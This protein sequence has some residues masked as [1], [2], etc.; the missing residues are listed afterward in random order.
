MTDVVG[1]TR[2]ILLIG[3]WVA[4]L[5]M[6][7]GCGYDPPPESDLQLPPTGTYELGEPLAIVFTEPIVVDSLAIRVWP[8]GPE[9]RTIENEL[10]PG[11][12]PAV[13]VCRV[14][15]G[16][17]GP[18]KLEVADDRL[19]A[20]LTLVG[21]PFDKAKVPWQ[22]EVLAGLRDDAGRESGAPDLFDFQFVPP[23]VC[24]ADHPIEFDDGVYVLLGIIEDPL[25]ATLIMFSDMKVLENGELRW[26]GGKATAIDGAP[27]N[28]SN[29]DE[30]AIDTTDKGFAIFPV[31]CVTDD[32]TE[33]F[34]TTEP[35]DLNLAF[36]PLLVTLS[37]LRLTGTIGKHPETGEDRIEGTISFSGILLD[38][39]GG[40]PFEYPPG[41]TGFFM[42]KVPLD[43]IPSEA[44]R[45]CG[46]L[47]GDITAQCNPPEG[48]PG[49]EFC[50]AEGASE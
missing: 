16:A 39:G 26:V 22:L 32:G 20:T 8:A 44:P 46:A 12:P 48:Y 19:S 24:G 21:A 29:P 33:R 47:C 9:D 42:D 11:V 14:A 38:S 18:A 4:S 15:D 37:G 5:A 41:N 10:V 40:E 49:E 27:K 2:S 6:W 50:E 45:M 30:L 36:G 3:V 13:D 35:F 25:P 1:M 7:S 34:L 43:K 23:N 17:C 31:G 28:T